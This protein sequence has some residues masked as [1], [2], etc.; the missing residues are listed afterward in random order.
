MAHSD[1]VADCDCIE[2]EGGAAGIADSLFDGLGD[3][4]KVD[5][6]RNDFAEA[7]CNGDEWFL[8]IGVGKAAGS[9]KGTVRRMLKTFFYGVAFHFQITPDNVILFEYRLGR[10]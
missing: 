6:A 3:F 10:L 7:V 8:D 2:F 5:V 9:Q 1:T 4:V